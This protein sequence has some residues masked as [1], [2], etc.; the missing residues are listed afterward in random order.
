MGYLPQQFITGKM[1]VLVVDPLEVV[2]V[3][4]HHAKGL[5]A[6]HTAGDAGLYFAAVVETGERVERS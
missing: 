1:T 5:L 6:R 2:E 3:D 4:N